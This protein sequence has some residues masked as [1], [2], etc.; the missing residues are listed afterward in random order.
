MLKD[1]LNNLSEEELKLLI[2]RLKIEIKKINLSNLKK[3][4]IIEEIS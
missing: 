4:M 2:E 1:K 3:K